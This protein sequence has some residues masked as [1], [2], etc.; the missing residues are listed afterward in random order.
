MKHTQG[1]WKVH[2]VDVYVHEKDRDYFCTVAK[3]GDYIRTK[4]EK[5][6]NARLIA[7]APELLKACKDALRDLLIAQQRLGM[8]TQTVKKLKQAIAKA[9]EI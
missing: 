7:S 1:E 6:A 8:E 5:E 3:G 9:E 4:E 2:G